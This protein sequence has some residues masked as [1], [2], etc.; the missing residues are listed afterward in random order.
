M[1]LDDRNYCIRVNL[2]TTYIFNIAERLN[3]LQEIRDWLDELTQW[4]PD[5]YDIQFPRK[6]DSIDVWFREQEHAM[7]FALRWS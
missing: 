7:L 3:E 5:M 6:S 4:Q 1:K 2:K